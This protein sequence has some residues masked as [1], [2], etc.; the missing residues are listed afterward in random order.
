VPG[1]IVACLRHFVPVSA[2]DVAWM[3]AS[4]GRG[5]LYLEATVD[6]DHRIH[7][8][9][10]SDRIGT[11]NLQ[12]YEDFSARTVAA[13][14]GDSSP[15]KNTRLALGDGNVA[16]PA[17]LGRTRSATQFARDGR[18]HQQ[19]IPRRLRPLWQRLKHLPPG[20]KSEV[21]AALAELKHKDPAAHNLL[22]SVPLEQ[23]CLAHMPVPTHGH[24]TS[25]MVEILAC[26]LL[27]ARR[28]ESLLGS[29]VWVLQWSRRRW[30]DLWDAA[31]RMSRQVRPVRQEESLRRV[32]E[33]ATS[34]HCSVSGGQ[35]TMHMDAV[36]T[37]DC[38]RV[39]L[40]TLAAAPKNLVWGLAQAWDLVAD[41]NSS[42]VR[43]SHTV[44]ISSLSKSDWMSVCDCGS[45]AHTWVMCPH[46]ATCLIHHGLLHT[47]FF[48]KP[49]LFQW[50]QQLGRTSDAN[51]VTFSSSAEVD[52]E[53]GNV[54]REV[55]LLA[56]E[57]GLY[58]VS[59]PPLLVREGRKVKVKGDVARY[60]TPSEV[61]TTSA[62]TQMRAASASVYGARPAGTPFVDFISRQNIAT[63]PIAATSVGASSS[64]THT[65]FSYTPSSVAV[66]LAPQRSV[67]V[68]PSP[69][70]SCGKLPVGACCAAEPVLVSSRVPPPKA[71]LQ[72]GLLL[73]SRVPPPG[74]GVLQ[75]A[76]VPPP[77]PPSRNQQY[78]FMPPPPHP[79][80]PRPLPVPPTLQQLPSQQSFVPQQ[81]L[82]VPQ[83]PV[84]H[85]QQSS[86]QQSSVLPLPSLPSSKPLRPSSDS[87]DGELREPDDELRVELRAECLRE[88][89]LRCKLHYWYRMHSASGNT[90]LSSVSFEVVLTWATPLTT[91]LS[92]LVSEL[93]SFEIESA[94]AV[95]RIVC[96]C[97][98][99]FENNRVPDF[100]SCFS[101][102]GV[103]LPGR[104]VNCSMAETLLSLLDH[105]QLR[106]VHGEGK[107]DFE[108]G[109]DTVVNIG[110]ASVLQEIQD[111]CPPVF[112]EA[113]V[114]S[115][116][117][118]DVLPEVVAEVVPEVVVPEVVTFCTLMEL[119]DVQQTILTRLLL[120]DIRKL[121]GFDASGLQTIFNLPMAGTCKAGLN[122]VCISVAAQVANTNA[123][124]ALL[125][126]DYD[127]SKDDLALIRNTTKTLRADP[128]LEWNS[129]QVQ[130]MRGAIPLTWACFNSTLGTNWVRA[131]AMDLAIFNLLRF[132]PESVMLLNAPFGDQLLRRT[133]EKMGRW[134]PWIEARKSGIRIRRLGWP[135]VRSGHWVGFFVDLEPEGG[136]MPRFHA[137][138]ALRVARAHP[139]MGYNPLTAE[140][141]GIHRAL[142]A[143]LQ[144]EY[145]RFG[146]S[147]AFGPIPPPAQWETRMMDIGTA[148]Q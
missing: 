143:A 140:F 76:F 113:E 135:H 46:T 92:Q 12:G 31:S 112:A 20:R 21:D 93:R 51:V 120:D 148:G 133:P 83:L 17:A 90:A 69:S 52:I 101:L 139:L 60:K 96:G 88:T 123:P 19:D 3:K 74:K 103:H 134:R 104:R 45:V 97:L 15:L 130:T 63:P 126:H 40:S 35:D 119:P 81:H 27:G 7:A 34:I 116:V 10:I 132:L 33:R 98:E 109:L 37:V 87:P 114:A 137:M 5:S 13:T 106:V 131:D 32:C 94:S 79:S 59:Q 129:E 128:D 105:D 39:G 58:R 142:V 41:S 42:S 125:L 43:Q 47:P 4:P 16:I 73:S 144:A 146:S 11:E 53:V 44:R 66:Q 49:W 77:L 1:Y 136:G 29:L 68:M 57:G 122:A 99:N 110:G 9:A 118:P 70:A 111:V 64:S 127:F 82:H 36:V 50:Q 89:P 121:V 6:A 55:L 85:S 141:E 80:T 75:P 56:R 71:V 86:V 147:S 28:S 18:H 25:N 24:T 2:L 108:L 30:Q 22:L 115:K 8:V 54:I 61:A 26:M 102:S 14:G 124:A 138:D 145:Q 48:N 84:V 91:A 107:I 78:A 67:P 38:N 72:D 95:N 23:W 65:T 62:Q 100:V 117:A